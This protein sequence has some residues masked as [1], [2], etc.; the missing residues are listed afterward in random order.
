MSYVHFQS[1]G[2]LLICMT[3]LQ[4]TNICDYSPYILSEFNAAPVTAVIWENPVALRNTV[5]QALPGT[6]EFRVPSTHSCGESIEDLI[7]YLVDSA[8]DI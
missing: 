8:Y 7:V 1:T 3:V 2:L 5:L 6:S 4:G